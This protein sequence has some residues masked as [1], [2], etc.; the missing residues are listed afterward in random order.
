MA[1][2]R[3]GTIGK[4][5]YKS[6]SRTGYT[7]F[8]TKIDNK[9]KVRYKKTRYDYDKPSRKKQIIEEEKSN[10]KGKDEKLEFYVPMKYYPKAVNGRN[11][12]IEEYKAA[13]ERI[14]DLD[15]VFY[16]MINS[17]TS[18]KTILNLVKNRILERQTDADNS[19]IKRKFPTAGGAQQINWQK[20]KDVGTYYEDRYNLFD[21]GEFFNT[22]SVEFKD[23]NIK[24]ISNSFKRQAIINSYGENAYQLT[25]KD[26][27]DINKA[28]DKAMQDFF[29]KIKY[30]PT[31]NIF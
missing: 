27:E 26:V 22:L 28:F 18:K 30:V 11:Y 6:P 15:K 1:K 14:K 2:A 16:D 7:I 17:E 10:I 23:G 3:T 21:S 12:P 25:T 9:P 31:G 24:I 13:Y 5:G 19:L 4:G 8:G 29:D 20:G